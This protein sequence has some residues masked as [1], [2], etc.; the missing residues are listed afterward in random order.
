[1]YKLF[2]R[3]RL[4]EQYPILCA[5][6]TVILNMVA[7]DGVNMHPAYS[8]LK[9]LYPQMY[10]T[11]L[12]NCMDNNFE[13]GNL[14]LYKKCSPWILTMPIQDNWK[15]SYN[16]DYIRKAFLKISSNY[17]SLGIASIAIQEG[18]IPIDVI[19]KITENMDFPEIN[20]YEHKE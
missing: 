2:D 20:Y 1:M 7:K 14:L 17:K 4:E 12:K 18:I 9:G 15:G 19:E 3:Q 5:K 8:V 10:E 16:L 11:V 13:E 6:E